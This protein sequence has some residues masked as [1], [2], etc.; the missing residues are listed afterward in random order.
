MLLE[1]DRVEFA[2]SS[3]PVLRGA[4]LKVQAGEIAIILGPNGAGKST[5]LRCLNGLLKPARG[6]VLLDGE[7]LASLQLARQMA[8]VSQS[9]HPN[10]MTVFDAVLLGRKPYFQW[11]P[12]QAD[13][14]MTAEVL[15]LVGL[16]NLSVRPLSEISGGE[17]QKVSLARALV[18][19]P[20]VL[21]LD[22][23][24]NNLDLRSQFEIL[25]LVHEAVQNRGIACVMVT[26]D[27]NLALRFGDKFIVLSEGIVRAQGGREIIDAEL[28]RT[29]Y[30]IES[31][32]TEVNGYRLIVPL[33]P[34]L[35]T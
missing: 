5:L 10:G 6:V 7:P 32:I 9:P 3:V 29:V 16:A 17:L 25:S 4:S 18:Q 8:Y 13:L 22:E 20:R 15:D 30:G 23:P 28:I 12:T 14:Q 31:A 26:H 1:V 24:T 27:V 21:L 34:S 33:D 11:W 19:Q 35:S 2:Y